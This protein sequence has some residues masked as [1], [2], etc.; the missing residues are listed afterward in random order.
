M[1]VWSD[2]EAFI[3]IVIIMTRRQNL[4]IN[5]IKRPVDFVG[6]LLALAVTSPILLVTMIVL[7]FANKGGFRGIFF[8]QER[9]G[10]Y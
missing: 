5:Y 7:F 8:T 10:K 6:A 2:Y 9:P 4:Y 3:I 1:L